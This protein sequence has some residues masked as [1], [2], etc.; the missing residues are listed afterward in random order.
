MEAR[1]ENSGEISAERLMQP[2]NS[3]S[4]LF[5]GKNLATTYLTGDECRQVLTEYI[6]VKNLNDPIDN[7]SVVVNK[8]M[9]EKIMGRPWGAEEHRLKSVTKKI[10]FE[11]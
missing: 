4:F 11:K 9:S 2:K 6:R 1:K 8:E 10:L 3:M 7:T 5:P